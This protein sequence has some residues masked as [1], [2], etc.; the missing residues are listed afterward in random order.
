M[1]YNGIINSLYIRLENIL[2]VAIYHLPIMYLFVTCYS[3][4]D[5]Q[6]PQ[7]PYHLTFAGIK[8]GL[9]S[10]SFSHWLKSPKKKV[11]NCS[12]EDYPPKEKMLR[13]VIWH[14]F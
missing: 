5:V 4:K 2:S 11:P 3:Y 6:I 12:L 9:I 7:A 13:R 1:H 10:E 14:L 8:G